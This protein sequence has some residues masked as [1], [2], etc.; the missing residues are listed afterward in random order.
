MTDQTGNAGQQAASP[1]RF[2][3]VKVNRADTRFEVW[4]CPNGDPPELA[5]AIDARLAADARHHGQDLVEELVERALRQA[6][7]RH[8]HGARP[9][10]RRH[11]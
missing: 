4:L 1:R 3:E 6:E 9:A 7:W 5:G 8:G 10:G 2:I 11:P